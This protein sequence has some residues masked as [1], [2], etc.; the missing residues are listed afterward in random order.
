MKRSRVMCG[1]LVLVMFVSVMAQPAQAAAVTD[2]PSDHWAY[3]AVVSLVNRG[4]LATFED[5]SFQGTNPVDR[6]TLAVALARILDEIEAGRVIGSSSDADLLRDLTNEFRKELV[7]YY[8]DKKLIEESLAETKKQNLTIE[9]RVNNV[10]AAQG[11][12]IETVAR[13]KADIMQEA[14]QT[15]ENLNKH[16]ELLKK[17]ET[18]IEANQE[19]IKELQTALI[20]LEESLRLQQSDLSKLQNWSAE[21]DGVV[22]LMDSQIRESLV[23][24][25]KKIDTLDQKHQQELKDVRSEIDELLAAIA[26]ADGEMLRNQEQLRSQLDTLAQRNV[27]LEKDIQSLAVRINA[28]AQANEAAIAELQAQVDYLSTQI[29]ISEEE[30]AALN[31]KISDEIAVQMNAAII[32]ERGL[33]GTVAELQAEFDSYKATVEKELKSA[34]NTAMIALAAA[35][36]GVIIGFIK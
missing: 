6:Y 23:E 1:L 27:Q 24:L 28:Q 3:Q 17:H 7:Q 33:S 9:D 14:M 21:K 15:A 8:A 31:K 13:L 35:A 12:L 5:G 36:V 19:R 18:N 2:V 29:G 16:E 11:E 32:R 22:A 10:V 26:K 25:A 34:K 4:F 30:L 20:R